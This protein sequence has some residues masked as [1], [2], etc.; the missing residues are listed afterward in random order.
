[1][2]VTFL[3][4]R[5]IR[6]IQPREGRLEYWDSVVVGLVLRASTQAKTWSFAY[7]SPEDTDAHGNHRRRRVTLGT[8]PQL[9][10]AEARLQASTLRE[11]VQAGEDP[12]PKKAEPK[13][14]GVM[15][16]DLAADYLERYA[17]P[18]KT[19]WKTDAW[20]MKTIWIPAFGNRKVDSLT[21]KDIRLV[22]EEIMKRGPTTANRVHGILRKALTWGVLHHDLATNPAR[23]IPTLHKGLPR[24]RVLSADEVRR[25]WHA[26]RIDSN[27]A[28]VYLPLRLATA[29]RAA[30][31][32]RLNANHLV[33]DGADLW[34]NVPAAMTKTRKPYRTFLSPL[35]QELLAPFRPS[36][37]GWYFKHFAHRMETGGMVDELTKRIRRV[38]GVENWQPRD[39]R[40][41]AAT[42]MAQRGVPRF[43][44]KRVLGHADR[45]I[46]A[47]YDLYTYDKEVKEAVLILEKAIREAIGEA[48]AP[49][50]TSPQTLE[51][52][53]E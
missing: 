15:F 13:P 29:Q 3:T 51:A 49:P 40:R 10:L 37:A 35:A 42:W 25:I 16:A 28:A 5:L 32:G 2:A 30:Q 44:L 36:P 33:Q 6:S 22:L 48:P 7:S 45:D 50:V 46:T 39:L 24:E 12:V 21:V 1:M 31:I 14:R 27:P 18:R 23:L 4:D 43:I 41:T 52:P 53:A 17:K 38:S 9:G 8:F 47:V 19:T 11:K 34:W 20:A 26:C